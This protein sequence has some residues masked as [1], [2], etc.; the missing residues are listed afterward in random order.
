MGGRKRACCSSVPKAVSV[1]A[2]RCSPMWLTGAPEPAALGEL[3]DE[4]VRQPVPHLGPEALVLGGEAKVH[5]DRQ[6]FGLS[7][8]AAAWRMASSWSMSRMRSWPTVPSSRASICSGVQRPSVYMARTSTGWFH[9]AILL[10][11]AVYTW[12][13][14]CRALSE[15]R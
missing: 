4:V 7:P 8:E 10:P 13:V 2:S 14:T 3:A 1:G 6:A 11:T 12:P 15:R 5:E 9:T